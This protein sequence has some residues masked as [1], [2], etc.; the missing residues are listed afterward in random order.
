MK[1]KRNKIVVLILVICCIIGGYKLYPHIFK[2]KGN[3]YSLK[4]SKEFKDCH[5]DGIQVF[6]RKTR[7]V[8][9][10]RNEVFKDCEKQSKEILDYLNT[11]KLIEVSS[12]KVLENENQNEKSEISQVTFTQCNEECKKD[13]KHRKIVTIYF[14]NNSNLNIMTFYKDY[15]KKYFRV[16]GKIDFK[17]INKILS[18]IKNS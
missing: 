6:R 8:K 17:Y 3:L 4:M 5:Y 13:Y 16:E 14:Y 7:E 12:K 2:E 1:K 15:T 18:S 9:E 10:V 11:F